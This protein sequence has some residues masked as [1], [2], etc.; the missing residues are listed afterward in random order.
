MATIE[1]DEVRGR[2]RRLNHL[3]TAYGYVLIASELDRPLPAVIPLLVSDNLIESEAGDLVK[4]VLR[5]GGAALVA[6]LEE[7][8]RLIRQGKKDPQISAALRDVHLTFQHT[9]RLH[10]GALARK[11]ERAVRAG[12]AAGPEAPSLRKALEAFISGVAHAV[13]EDDVEFEEVFA[14]ED[15]A[16]DGEAPVSIEDGRGALEEEQAT[17]EPPRLSP[18]E[19]PPLPS[20]YKER[21]ETPRGGQWDLNGSDQEAADQEGGAGAK[22]RPLDWLRDRVDV[23][24]EMLARWGAGEA[25]VPESSP[26]VRRGRLSP[27]RCAEL[28]H[29]LLAEGA[30]RLVDR[31]EEFGAASGGDDRLRYLRTRIADGLAAGVPRILA[32]LVSAETLPADLDGAPPGSRGALADLTV[33]LTR[34]VD[35]FDEASPQHSRLGYLASEL[36]SALRPTSA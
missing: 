5:R 19:E 4:E 11:M 33:Y 7:V 1:R 21:P 6:D 10:A 31:I 28:Y 26:L 32:L 18:D 8:E 24:N 35:L 29:D 22:E 20:L 36:R 2:L 25:F 23:Y 27:E 16:T 9:A 12:V 17:E 30:S 15:L 3:V 13:R 34:A 14:S